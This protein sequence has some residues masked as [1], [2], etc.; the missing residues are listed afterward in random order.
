MTRA[1]DLASPQKEFIQTAQWFFGEVDV[2]LFDK[3]VDHGFET[4]VLSIGGREDLA[5][6]VLFEFDDLARG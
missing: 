1:S 5:Y 6:P 4:K 2:A 3:D